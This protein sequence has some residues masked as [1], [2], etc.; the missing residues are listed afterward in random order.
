M[1]HCTIAFLVGLHHQV[2]ADDNI[3]YFGAGEEPLIGCNSLVCLQCEALVKHVDDRA[4]GQ[5]YP[6]PR[7]ELGAL[8]V[9]PDPAS[10]QWLIRRAMCRTYFCRCDWH[11]VS[12]PQSLNFIE[13]NWACGGH[14]D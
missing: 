1:P 14:G 7:E 6:P 9:S 12:T 3:G 2:P 13:Q 8:Y 10:S 11:F 4:K 5:A